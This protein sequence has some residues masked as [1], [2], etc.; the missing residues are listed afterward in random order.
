MCSFVPI[1]SRQGLQIFLS[2]LDGLLAG[3]ALRFNVKI[4]IFGRHSQHLLQK[5]TLGNGIA[6]PTEYS[7]KMALFVSLQ[8]VSKHA[9]D[10]PSFK[11]TCY[12]MRS[13]LR[14]TPGIS[15]FQG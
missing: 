12:E 6:Q 2:T 7:V 1:V 4:P 14:T 11:S 13:V 10:S 5:G 3:M 15:H 9:L 8:C